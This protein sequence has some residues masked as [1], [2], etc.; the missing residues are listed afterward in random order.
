MSAM[1]AIPVSRYLVPAEPGE[2][3]ADATIVD[4]PLLTGMP[5]TVAL[6]ADAA[7]LLTFATGLAREWRDLVASDVVAQSTIEWEPRDKPTD[8]VTDP[9]SGRLTLALQRGGR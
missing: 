2:P 8:P 7:L 3:P 9:L 4:I 5:F 1:P 6:G